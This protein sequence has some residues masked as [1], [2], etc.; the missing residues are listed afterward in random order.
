MSA[1]ATRSIWQRREPRLALAGAAVTVV[2]A[3]A[4]LV[5]ASGRDTP[6]ASRS[7]RNRKARSAS[8][9]AA[10][11]TQ[12]GWK[13]H[14]A[15]LGFPPLSTTW[16]PEWLASNRVSGPRLGRMEP[17]RSAWQG[18]PATGRSLSRGSN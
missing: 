1:P 3:L 4:L 2:A 7:K 16:R 10:S 6:A 14:S 15:K 5:S 17:A 8:K 12:R 18:L 13:M 11:K 9:S